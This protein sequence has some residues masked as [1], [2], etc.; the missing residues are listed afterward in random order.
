MDTILLK[1]K[2]VAVELYDNLKF[3]IKTLSSIGIT[4]KLAAILVGNDPASQVYVKNKSRAFEKQNCKSQTFSFPSNVKEKEIVDLIHS[5]NNDED[6]H[7]ILIQL[8]LPN[9]LDSK[10]IINSVSPDKDV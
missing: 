3:R 5:L 7:G 8:P 6:I 1:G 2:P 10:K 9:T 4:P